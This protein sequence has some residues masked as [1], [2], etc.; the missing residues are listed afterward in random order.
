MGKSKQRLP[1]GTYALLGVSLI[2]IF[3]FSQLLLALSIVS[4]KP[5]PAFSASNTGGFFFS[6]A[7]GTSSQ[8]SALQVPYTNGTE[9]GWEL[10]NIS[11][12]G[13]RKFQIGSEKFSMFINLITPSSA[14]FIS[15]ANNYTINDGQTIELQSL[16]QEVYYA[17]LIR[18]NYTQ[19]NRRIDMLVYAVPENETH[20]TTTII[21]TTLSTTVSTTISTTSITVEQSVFVSQTSALASQV[22]TLPIIVAAIIAIVWA[23]YFAKRVRSRG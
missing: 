1:S 6:S 16:G 20:A 7:N 10:I 9:T 21:R 13:T 12:F 17:R 11:N 22:D 18:I 23:S 3:L 15:N 14:S 4:I 2:L 8:S 19:N 5:N